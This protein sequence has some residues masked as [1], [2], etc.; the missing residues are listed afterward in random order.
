MGWKLERGRGRMA[1]T[2]HS[3]IEGTVSVRQR[4]IEHDA[5][6]ENHG[7]VGVV[8]RGP[9]WSS[10]LQFAA[11]VLRLWQRTGRFVVALVQQHLAILQSLCGALPE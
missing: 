4:K 11:P 3:G 1:F 7:V 8:E 9:K 6:A 10:E 5:L 2:D